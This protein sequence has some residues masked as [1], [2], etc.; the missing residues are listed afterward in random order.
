MPPLSPA[1]I[2]RLKMLAA[3]SDDAIDYSDIP[4]LTDEQFERMALIPAMTESGSRN[5]HER[6][7]EALKK[8]AKKAISLRLDP[9]VY[10][11]FRAQGPRYQS[12]MHAVLK[13]YMESHKK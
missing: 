8:K 2:K 13:A 12:H 10:T 11:W 5:W 1:D 9:D 7:K 3:R 4:P 6:V